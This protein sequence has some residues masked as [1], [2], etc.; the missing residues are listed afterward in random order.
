MHP[1]FIKF[2][3][4][5]N[6]WFRT[7][8]FVDTGATLSLMSLHTAQQA[9]LRINTK[10]RTS[11]SQITGYTASIGRTTLRLTIGS[12]TKQVA[13]DVME[14]FRYPLLLGMDIGA[15]FQIIADLGSRRAF[16]KGSPQTALTTTHQSP[17]GSAST[18]QGAASFSPEPMNP[19]PG[20]TTFSL[21]PAN[22]IVGLDKG[23]ESYPAK[24]NEVLNRHSTLFAQSNNDLG[25]ITVAKHRIRT[26]DQNPIYTRPFRF[27]I[28][29]ND[30][31]RR[32]VHELIQQRRVRPSVSPY[33]SP[34]FMVK[35]KDGGQRMV[36]D[37]SKLNNVTI[38]DRHP[39]P[40]IQEVLD[41]LQGKRVFSVL[42][43]AW[44]FWQVAMD[45]ED[46]QKTAFSTSDGH[47]EWIC[48]PMGLKGAPA[49]FQRIIQTVL[50]DLLYTCVINYLDDLIIYSNN[51][52]DHL[53]HL[54]RVFDR[55]KQHGVKLKKEKCSFFRSS[56][57]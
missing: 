43:I 15:E 56:V 6:G 45:P 30:E 57:E 5:I 39:L 31:I 47:Y 14:S 2:P 4:S 38:S 25:L 48:M 18:L 23:S 20:P 51:D 42:D 1:K 10:T 12:I 40:L 50:G 19:S 3:V 11:L 32:Q 13:I 33:N 21:G 49:T 54:N 37:Y 36:L 22:Q 27:S 35:K 16:L 26:A 46:I 17:E 29:E 44:G 7:H 52:T 34:V 8:A 55:L 53:E 41:R 9:K 28:K 24:F